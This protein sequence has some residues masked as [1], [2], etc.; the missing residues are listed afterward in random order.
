MKNGYLEQAK[1]KLHDIEQ[2][3][4][5]RADG[6]LHLRDKQ[7]AARERLEALEQANKDRFDILRR[8]FEDAWQELSAAYDTVREDVRRKPRDERVDSAKHP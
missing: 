4:A 8:G 2:A 1:K 7:R 3:I 5:K 6:A